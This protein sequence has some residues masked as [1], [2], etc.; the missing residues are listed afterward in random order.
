MTSASSGVGRGDFKGAVR[1]K[2]RPCE[3]RAGLHAGPEAP[4]W[5]PVTAVHPS[6]PRRD[7]KR[8][9][10]RAAE[11]DTP[12]RLQGCDLHDVASTAPPA[13]TNGPGTAPSPLV[14]EQTHGLTLARRAP[15]SLGPTPR[16]SGFSDAKYKQIFNAVSV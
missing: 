1:G 14:S 13:Q 12:R 8:G 11:A 2:E 7:N 15:I 6:T 3:S 9:Q 4:R 10:E 16:L 5:S